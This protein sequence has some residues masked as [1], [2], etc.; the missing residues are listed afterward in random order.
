MNIPFHKKKQNC[1][2]AN[3]YVELV[4]LPI[5]STDHP[6]MSTGGI[7]GLGGTTPTAGGATAPAVAASKCDGFAGPT[8]PIVDGVTDGCCWTP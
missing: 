2:A 7:K 6:C 8:I 5:C 4:N 3:V 1:G